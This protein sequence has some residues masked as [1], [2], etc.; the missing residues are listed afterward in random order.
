MTAATLDALESQFENKRWRYAANRTELFN[1]GTP[2]NGIHSAKFFVAQSGISLG[3]RHQFRAIP[4]RKRVIGIQAGPSSVAALRI[5][6]H[7]IDAVWIDFPLPPSTDI[8]GA[9]DAIRCR[10][11]LQHETFHASR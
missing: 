11:M 9:A 3:E 7:A 8:L 2:D 5:H 6:Q 10:L 1:S 4:H